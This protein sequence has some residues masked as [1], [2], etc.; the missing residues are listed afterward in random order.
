MLIDAL[1]LQTRLRAY[2]SPYNLI[3]IEWVCTMIDTLVEQKEVFEN[4]EIV[5]HCENMGANQ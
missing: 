1:E 3:S 5:E 2:N 4:G